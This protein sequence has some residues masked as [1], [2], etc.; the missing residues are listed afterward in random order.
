MDDRNSRLMIGLKKPMLKRDKA[1]CYNRRLS[2]MT[3]INTF[4]FQ[5][6]NSMKTAPG[7]SST[8]QAWKKL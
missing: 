1:Y 2:A 7:A 5:V 4:N 6:K 8:P 3:Q